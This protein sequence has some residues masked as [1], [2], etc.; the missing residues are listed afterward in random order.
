MQQPS[1]Q[2]GPP[3]WTQISPQPK[4]TRQTG[5]VPPPAQ[6]EP[7]YQTPYPQGG[8]APQGQSGYAPQGPGGY[9]PQG[10]G[11]YAQPPQQGGPYAPQQQGQAG[12]APGRA[13]GAA[14]PPQQQ[15]AAGP[16]PLQDGRNSPFAPQQQIPQQQIPQQG[17]QQQGRPQ[18]QADQSKRGYRMPGT[19]I[20]ARRRRSNTPYIILT[21]V[22]LAAGAFAVIS[23][24]A[25]REAMYGYVTGGVLSSRYAGDAVVVRDEIVY[26]QEG[27]SRIDYTAEEGAD[28]DR[29]TA[30]CTVYTSGFNAR[31]LTTLK[32]YRDQIKDYHKTLIT[33]PGAAKDARLA[34]LDSAVREQAENTRIMIQDGRGSLVYQEQLLTQSLQARQSY[35]R[36]KYP[37]DQKLSRLYDDE[38]TQMQRI[39]SWTKQFAAAADGIISFYTDGYEPT[40]NM[41]TYGNYAPSEVRTMYNGTPPAN[42]SATRNTVSVY[43]LVKED[44]WAVLMLSDD[45]DWTPVVGQNYR[46]LIENFDATVVDAL[47]ESFT[48]SGGELLVR[49]T[50][51]G[52]DVRPIL[53]TRSC[54]VQLGENVDSL[55]IPTRALYSQMGQTGVVI[56]DENGNNYFT[57]VTV[58]STQGDVTHVIPKNS[59]YLYEGMIVKLF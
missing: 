19:G 33:S 50:V 18:G 2:P 40:V 38:N 42:T 17:P 52:A 46:L 4:N 32:K 21:L 59:G 27:V 36:Q 41:L 55:T 24:F 44:R 16:Q 3:D 37:D 57:P 6:L 20:P 43:R 45:P 31:E 25:P 9:V 8:Y 29:T 14:P 5:S 23:H 51:Q 48:R 56:V 28:V 30:V 1:F 58:I 13:P 11:G 54:R 15:P 10:Q 39:S 49:L 47:V 26:T 53:Y 34:S 22:I 35:L 12:Y 7:E